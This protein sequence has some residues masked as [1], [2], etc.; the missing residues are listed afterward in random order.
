MLRMFWSCRQTGP[1]KLSKLPLN[2]MLVFHKNSKKNFVFEQSIEIL[3][4][5]IKIAQRGSHKY[6]Q[7]TSKIGEF[8]IAMLCN[9]M[10]NALHCFYISLAPRNKFAVAL[11]RYKIIRNQKNNWKALFQKQN[12]HNQHFPFYYS[13][14]EDEGYFSE[15][16]NSGPEPGQKLLQI[17]MN[18][19]RLDLHWIP[20]S[21]S[22][23]VSFSEKLFR[24]APGWWNISSCCKMDRLLSRK[25]ALGMSCNTS[26]A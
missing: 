17:Q 8:Y 5:K 16:A 11:K 9:E 22:V 4:R 10:Y 7:M 23:P 19:S 1:L 26:F 24:N 25:H 15:S 21:H 18:E 2:V 12:A 14:S 20:K 13:Q 6:G 3:E